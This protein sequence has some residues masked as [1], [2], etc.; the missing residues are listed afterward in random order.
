[1][2]LILLIKI[3]CT[4]F[5]YFKK[6]LLNKNTINSLIIKLSIRKD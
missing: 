2:K 6:H 4:Y 5:L 3:I 1:M